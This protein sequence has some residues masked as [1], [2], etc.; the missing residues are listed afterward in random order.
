MIAID[1]DEQHRLDMNHLEETIESLNATGN[2]RILA[3]VG[4]GG[5]TE[6][7]TIDPLEEIATLCRQRQIHFHV[8]AAWGG[9]TL[10]SQ[11]YKTLLRGIKFADSVTI[12]GH[13]QFYMPMSCGMLYFK[14]PR[15]LDTI[16][17]HSRY[18][19]R[20]GSVDL[21]I[22]SLSGSRE[23]NSL[24]LDSALKIMGSGGYALLIENG[25]RVAHKFADEIE[26]RPD[27]ELTSSPVLNILTYRFFPAALRDKLVGKSESEKRE[28]Y[29]TVNEINISLQRNQREAGN[30]FVSR[31]T[32]KGIHGQPEK[33]VV[34]R[35]VL[36]NPMTTI[37]ILKEILDE[38][39]EIYRAMESGTG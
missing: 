27:F 21:G 16:A 31:T 37:S 23:A 30:S 2:T 15:A 5:A 7:G 12:D 39:E 36:M 26:R 28:I 20:P 33:C 10:L 4:L 19:N 9:P 3:V 38:Q 22:K 24:I 13:K 1:V 25:I 29:E 6:T 18:I 11:K 35:V 32:L 17:Y 34:L 14:D 8:D